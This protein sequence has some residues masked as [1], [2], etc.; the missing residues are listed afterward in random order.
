MLYIVPSRGRPANIEALIAAWK[1]TRKH[2]KLWICVDDDDPTLDGYKTLAY[3]WWASLHVGPR[4][5]LGGTLNYW[6]PIAADTGLYQ[7]IG[8]MGDDHRPRTA[9]WDVRIMRAALTQ[10]NVGVF[11]PNDL[12]QG[13][14]LATSVAMT[15]NVVNALGY[16]CP[17]GMT[18]L[19]LDNAWMDIGNHMGK[20]TYLPQVIVEHCHPIANKGVQWDAGYAEVNSGEMYEKDREIY[21]KWVEEKEWRKRLDTLN[22]E[23]YTLENAVGLKDNSSMTLEDAVGYR[24]EAL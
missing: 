11:Y 8:F 7:V 21:L 1:G 20:L 15:A 12:I 18:H 24:K 5:K 19:Y 16:F 14:A 9:H 2:A 13:A 3:P 22:V 17:P 23:T 10:K 4:M 6:A